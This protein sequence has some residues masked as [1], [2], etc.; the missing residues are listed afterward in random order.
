MV[1]FI[2][3]LF[4]IAA[5]LLVYATID[6]DSCCCEYEESDDHDPVCDDD[7]CLF[8]AAGIVGINLP[9]NNFDFKFNTYQPLSLLNKTSMVGDFIKDLDQPPRA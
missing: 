3:I 9:E 6:I 4:L 2:S 8:C 7:S 5:G 1:K